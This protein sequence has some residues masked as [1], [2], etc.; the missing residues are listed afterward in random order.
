MK[1]SVLCLMVTMF[2][3]IMS[4]CGPSVKATGDP[5]QDGKEMASKIMEAAQADDLDGAKEIVVVFYDAYKDAKPEDA[6][7][8]A[9]TVASETAQQA[10]K[11]KPEEM[12]KVGEFMVKLGKTDEGKKMD[13]IGQGNS[14][15]E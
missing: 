14:G 12:A 1:K 2:L 10:M 13:Q 5:E 9:G 7:L 11:L 4:A 15:E 8:F 6:A 3:A